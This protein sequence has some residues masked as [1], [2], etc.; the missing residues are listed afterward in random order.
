[1]ADVVDV[2][3]LAT[4]KAALVKHHEMV[5]QVQATAKA[6]DAAI[7]EVHAN[8]AV[9]RE[10]LARLEA[11]AKAKEGADPALIDRQAADLSAQVGAAAGPLAFRCL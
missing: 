1:M 3:Q 7:Q 10:T 11:E 5:A 2:A 9:A 4:L 8:A 6:I